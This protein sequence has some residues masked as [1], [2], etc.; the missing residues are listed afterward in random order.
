MKGQE[1]ELKLEDESAEAF[2][3][4]DDDINAAAGLTAVML[5]LTFTAFETTFAI[6]ALSFIADNLNIVKEFTIEG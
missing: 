2:E 6:R 1:V 3:E 4:K 5:Q